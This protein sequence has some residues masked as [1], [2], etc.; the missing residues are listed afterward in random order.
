MFPFVV[1]CFGCGVPCLA[2]FFC[3]FA[4]S[5]FTF[6]MFGYDFGAIYIKIDRSFRKSFLGVLGCI[7]MCFFLCSGAGV[8]PVLLWDAGVHSY[9]NLGC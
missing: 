6:S 3:L 9:V 5:V 7:L 1:P 8:H 4:P 2:P